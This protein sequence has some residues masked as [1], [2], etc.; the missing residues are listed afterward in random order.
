MGKKVDY[1]IRGGRVLDPYRGLD[2]VCDIAVKDG[3]IVS[4]ED[5]DAAEEVNAEGCIVTPGL[6]DFHCHVCSA[7]SDLPAAPEIL[8]FPTG[9]TTAVDAGSSG[10]ANYEAFR[11]LTF[12]SRVRILAYLNVCPAGLATKAYHENLDPAC[13]QKNTILRYLK[14]YKDQ[15]L[16]L[17]LRSSKELV[18]EYGLEPLR[19]MISIAEEAHCPVVVHTTNP[20]VPPEELAGLLRAGDVYAHVYQGKGDTV[21]RNGHVIE[22]MREHQKRGVIF[23]AANGVNHFSLSV[24]QTCMA[25][26]FLPD[27]IS[28]DLTT[29]SAYKPG[30]VFSLPFILSKY[31]ALGMPLLEIIRRVT[32]NPARVIGQEQ[33]LGSLCEGTCADITISREVLHHTDFRDFAG[34][35]ING[36]RLL[37]TE[38]TM[39]EGEVVYR[40]IEF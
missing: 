12:N 8:C 23:D 16:G 6:I 29:K 2:A 11:F 13:F 4:S 33:E 9:V 18:G 21:V 39:R 35:S 34:N 24:A 1:L 32:T 27:I 26:G 28:T 7:I 15:L 17:K 10:T 14:K 36:D 20:P 3:I 37:R 38:L 22:E 19:T 30:M 5:A 25:E 31:I 40:Q